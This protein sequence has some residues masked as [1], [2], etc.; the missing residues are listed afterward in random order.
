MRLES[1]PQGLFLN[2]NTVPGSIYQVQSAAGL[3]A[4]GNLGGPRYAA[5]QL[6]SL[7]V[8]GNG[9]GYYRIVRLR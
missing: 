7:Y 3:D 5:G 6:D 4:W 9:A 1:T 8:G 2:W